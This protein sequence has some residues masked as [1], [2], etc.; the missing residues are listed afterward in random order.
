MDRLGGKEQPMQGVNV[1]ARWIDPST[2]QPS[3]RYGAASVSGYLFTGNAGNPITGLTDALGNAY[4]DFGS[5]DQTLEGFFDLGGLP[6]PNGGSTAQYQLSVEALDPL[7]SSGVCPYDPSPVVPSGTFQ[8]VV[9]TVSAGGDLEQNIVMTASA[10]AVPA[11]AATETW[12]APAPVPSPGD[13]VGSLNGYGDVAYF[14]IA[15]QSNRTLSVAVTALSGNDI[16]SESGAQPVVGIWT[17]GDPVGTPPPALTT[18]PFNSATFAMSRLDAQVLATNSFIIGIA[19][20][21]RLGQSGPRFGQ[22]RRRHP[23]RDRLCA[24]AH[25]WRGNRQCACVGNE[26]QPDAGCRVRAG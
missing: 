19:D 23:A 3:R 15:A 26:C 14:L 6:I 12:N 1:V 10:Q 18:A 2:N 22:W 24:W 17:L 5:S 8:P 13:W 7:W 20:L 11:W 25:G 16:P 21:R 4:S 9:V